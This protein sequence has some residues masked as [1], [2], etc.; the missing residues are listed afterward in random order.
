MKVLCID[1]GNTSAHYGLVEGQT[2]Y[3]TG[4]L[5]TNSFREGPWPEFT[6]LVRDLLDQADGIAF[7]SVVPAINENLK[8]SLSSCNLPVFHLNCNT[9]T[10][11]NL[12]Y[13]KPEEIG[14]DRIAN[15][16][17]AQEYYGVPAIVIDMGTA[18]T[19][20][21][22]TSQGYEGG[23]IAPGLKVMTRY[24]HE[25]TALLPELSS[26]E[27]IDVEGA[28]GKSTVHAMKLGVAVGF[29]GMIN[30]LR[31]RVLDE[32]QEREE[33]EPVVLS[34][35]GSIANLTKDWTQKSRFVE[36]LTLM[37]LAVAFERSRH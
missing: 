32:L 1:V 9:C 7:C 29:S 14:Q 19:F 6:K 13:P 4:D 3:E 36:N 11:L 25:Q 10:G 34:T 24:L 20:D 8:Q 22:I 2:V 15:A 27:L 5:R 12:A 37:G 23:I 16:I 17:A 30:A 28:I 21:I 33:S 18:V 31:T 26:K 35:G